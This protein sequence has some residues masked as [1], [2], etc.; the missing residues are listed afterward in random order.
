MKLDF[1]DLCNID[2]CVMNM[3][4][5]RRDP[6]VSDL[7]PTV[8]KRGVIVPVILRPGSEEGRFEIVAGRRRVQAAR[9]ACQEEGADPELARLPAAIMAAG[10]DAAA[11]EASL[12]ENLA[13]LDPDEVS[14]WESFVRLVKQGRTL[15]DL[16]STFG[17]PEL[18]V[19]R[20]L[21][22]G[23]LLPR[24]RELYRRD[25]IDA[26]TVRHLTLATKSQ[27]RAWLALLDDP[28]CHAPVGHQ[29]KGWLFGG[30]AIPVR[31]ALFDLAA[32]PGT[33]LGDLF[34]EDRYFADA[35]LFWTEQNRVIE[36]RRERY[37]DAGWSDAVIVPPTEHF[38]QWEY[39]KTSKRGGGRVYI[40]VRSNGE[41]AFHEGYLS[42]KAAGRAR[43]NS[44]SGATEGKVARPEL[45][46]AI[47]DYVNLHRHAAV[48]AALIGHG[49]VALR[50]MAAHAIAGS[51]LFRVSPEPQTARSDALRESVETSVGETVFDS[52]RRSV[53]GLLGFCADDPSV[54]GGSFEATQDDQENGVARDPLSAVFARLLTLSDKD[55]LRVVTIVMGE[56]LASG[57]PVI[58]ALGLHM[59]VDMANWWEA[60]T[61]FL[62][63]VRDREVLGALLDDVGGS[64]VAVAN[65]GEKTKV[66]RTLVQDH[67]GGANG[68]DKKD[69]WVPLWMQFPPSAY[70]GRGGVPTVDAHALIRADQARGADGTTPILPLAA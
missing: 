61:V 45:T 48:R 1:I 70:T 4:H 11:L 35:D 5:S 27:Q 10:D 20:I 68:R 56:A 21:A 23:N 37:L 26:T 8:R 57:S 38:H 54:I 16:S 17:L 24:I 62:E 44:G 50:L 46:S 43:R 67:L 33:I 42:R 47:G 18:T 29:L 7:L 39:E 25:D 40:V 30:Q 28:D 9:L 41:V 13:R 59:Q 55:V 36:T 14:R 15:E 52:E 51:R 60:D 12:I 65:A 34:G 2:V 3:R 32:F 64:A 53:L 49:H 31:H 63:L 6:D 66:L 19:R 69:R 58:E 22:L